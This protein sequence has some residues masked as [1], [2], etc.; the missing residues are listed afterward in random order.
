MYDSYR[1]LESDREEM[2]RE[3]RK[4]LTWIFSATMISLLCF[5]YP[6][7]RDYKPKWQAYRAS[8]K[9]AIFLS[10]MKNQAIRERHA[11]EAKFVGADKIEVYKVSGCGP[12]A[13]HEKLYEEK[14]TEFAPEVSFADQKWIRKHVDNTQPL[15][16]RYCYDPQFGS[17]V[18]AD[19]FST[20]AIYLMHSSIY[21][22]S[23]DSGEDEFAEDWVAE[24]AVVGA[25]GDISI[26]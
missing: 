9:L 6:I 18:H 23:F 4:R 24:L 20:G 16:T 14:L 3:R 10:E 7:I 5:L 13:K 22:K 17:S 15:L 8:R 12:N 19:G 26:Q 25:N 11:F 1:I 21:Q 2:K